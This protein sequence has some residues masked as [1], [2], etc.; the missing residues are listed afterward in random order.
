MNWVRLV[1]P[2]RSATAASLLAADACFFWAKLGERSPP[3]YA[4]AQR[5]GRAL[6]TLEALEASGARIFFG[7][8]PEFRAYGTAGASADKGAAVCHA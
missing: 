5:D 7:H 1:A 6:D 4:R 2:T 8:Y 3:R